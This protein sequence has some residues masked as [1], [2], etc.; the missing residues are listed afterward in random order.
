[1]FDCPRL[2]GTSPAQPTPRTPSPDAPAESA[3]NARRQAGRIRRFGP[4]MLCAATLGTRTSAC[5]EE[6]QLL[7]AEGAGLRLGRGRAHASAAR[8]VP[9]AP[10]W[11]APSP[12][13]GKA[14][15]ASPCSLLAFAPSTRPRRGGEAGTGAG[16]L[17]GAVGRRH[18]CL[19]FFVIIY[20]KI[21]VPKMFR[22]RLQTAG[23][24][25][26]SS[27]GTSVTCVAPL[28]RGRTRMGGRPLSTASYSRRVARSPRGL[29]S[30]GQA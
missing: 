16:Y 29:L 4:S 12:A 24:C 30:Q 9:A 19:L 14:P 10:V 13:R 21:A 26:G 28:L 20:N 3:D 1:M 6:G 11:P 15:P 18:V 7:Q 2:R 8:S 22:E 25:C 5:S 23:I 27:I 17:A